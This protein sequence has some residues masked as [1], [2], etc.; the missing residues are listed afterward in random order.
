[1]IAAPPSIEGW[2]A[3]LDWAHDV[4]QRVRDHYRAHAYSITEA[5]AV[6]G[7]RLIAAA[8][9]ALDARDA[10]AFR[11]AMTAYG[12]PLAGPDPSLEGG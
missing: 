12:A 4:A 9:V 6:R 5:E 8:R 2:P 11:E 3:L 7:K 10:V 1:M